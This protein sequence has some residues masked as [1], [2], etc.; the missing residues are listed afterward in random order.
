M[1]IYKLLCLYLFSTHFFEHYKTEDVTLD[2]F[3]YVR[4]YVEQEYLLYNGS[5][6]KDPYY[7]LNTDT[8]LFVSKYYQNQ[9]SFNT[10]SDSNIELLDKM[11]RINCLI[12]MLVVQ[13]KVYEIQSQT[14]YQRIA[15]E[16][17]VDELKLALVLSG[18]T[19]AIKLV[20]NAEEMVTNLIMFHAVGLC[21][22][23]NYIDYEFDICKA[24]IETYDYQFN[25]R[26][27]F[28]ISELYDVIGSL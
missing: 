22:K 3:E 10:F 21:Y 16:W 5:N 28:L 12:C 20:P 13:N 9:C 7:L 6:K 8:K 27:N 11:D 24:V 18:C 19:A 2:R 1:E 26:F 17:V 14:N 4:K 15:H 25:Y 23:S